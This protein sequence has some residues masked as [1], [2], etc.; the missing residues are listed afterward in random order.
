MKKVKLEK[1]EKDILDSFERGEWKS[2]K[3]VEAEG[4]RYNRIEREYGVFQRTFQMPD[5]IDADAI[6]AKSEHGVLEI[7]V[8]K[9]EKAHK[10]IEVL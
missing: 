8:P 6:T 2:V 4:D 7:A 10:K 3:N 9:A 1:E 5:N